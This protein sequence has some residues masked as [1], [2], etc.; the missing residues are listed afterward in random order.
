VY[1]PLAV[2]GE[3]TRLMAERWEA[4]VGRR[5]QPGHPHL[6]VLAPGIADVDGG[7]SMA[8][9]RLHLAGILDTAQSRGISVKVLGPPPG[10]ERLQARIEDFSRALEDVTT[11]RE[12][13]FVDC[14]TPLLAHEQWTEEMNRGDGHH[15]SHV[16]YG[17]IAWL[18]MHAGFE[19]WL[20]DATP[21]SV[22]VAQ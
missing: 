8:R 12:I 15:P 6:L 16:G 22:S 13:C 9:S 17:L 11:R 20:A 10:P 14:F 7:A 3:T 2:Q 5:F 4:E 19:S 1:F 21:Q 18:V